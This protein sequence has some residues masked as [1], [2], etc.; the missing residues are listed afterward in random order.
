ML[1]LSIDMLSEDDLDEI[2]A[3]EAEIARVSFPGDPIVDPQFHRRKLASAVGR[4]GAF[5]ARVGD[6]V[7]GWAWIAM[8]ENFSSKELYADFRSLYVAPAFR[9]GRVTFGLMRACID[10]CRRQGLRRMVGRTSATNREMQAI[11]RIFGFTARHIVYEL[12]LP[13]EPRPAADRALSGR[14]GG[15]KRGRGRR[16]SRAP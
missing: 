8:R 1:R 9:G 15:G 10:Y 7:A 2:A 3:F 5:V 16:G 14:K 11:Y 6:A 4:D 13:D 12:E